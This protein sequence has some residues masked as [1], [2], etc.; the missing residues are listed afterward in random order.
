MS[1]LHG[2]VAA[3]HAVAT[4][5]ER[6]GLIPA[7]AAQLLAVADGSIDNALELFASDP[8]MFNVS[9][10]S[11]LAGPHAFYP[12]LTPQLGLSPSAA[13][14]S[15]LPAF[16]ES[17]PVAAALATDVDATAAAPLP[18]HA[19]DDACASRSGTA[20]AAAVAPVDAQAAPMPARLS[21]V[22][23]AA[24]QER[25]WHRQRAAKLRVKA[26]KQ[27]RREAARVA[28]EAKVSQLLRHVKK[29]VVR[30]ESIGIERG[31]QAAIAAGKQ[32]AKAKKKLGKRRRGQLA[33]GA[34]RA[35]RQAGRSG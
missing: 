1:E 22:R 10:H 26:E 34:R 14:A 21:H 23:S 17:S 2:R 32:R 19:H 35:A 4:L 24:G 15:R 11:L 8:D 9:Q 3:G 31:V 29:Q 20:A 18:M 6:T 30:A 12:G 16:R 13:S 27:Q 7:H 5:R 28:Q 25:R 33:S